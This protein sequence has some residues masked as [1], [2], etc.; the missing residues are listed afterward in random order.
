MLRVSAAEA[1]NRVIGVERDGQLLGDVT[2]RG[3]QFQD[4]ELEIPGNPN[5]SRVSSLVWHFGVVEG[6]ESPGVKVDRLSYRRH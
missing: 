3:D 4:V 6:S 2:V 1:R 5:R